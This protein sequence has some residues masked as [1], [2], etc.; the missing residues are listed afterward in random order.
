MILQ[1]K[2]VVFELAYTH[3][4]MLAAN[5]PNA[6]LSGTPHLSNQVKR[7]SWGQGREASMQEHPVDP[8]HVGLWESALKS[9]KPF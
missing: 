5:S 6:I 7:V 9:L 1:T 8:G 2:G 4:R 3:I